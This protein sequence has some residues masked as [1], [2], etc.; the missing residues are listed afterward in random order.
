MFA[1]TMT[2]ICLLNRKLK[3]ARFAIGHF[4]IEKNGSHGAFGRQSFIAQKLVVKE[5][6]LTNE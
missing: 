2:R 1:I 6:L 4:R 3:Y 5:V